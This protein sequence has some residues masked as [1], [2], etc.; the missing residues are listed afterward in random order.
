M[1][2]RYNV[3]QDLQFTS[4]AMVKAVNKVYQNK[5]DK[6]HTRWGVTVGGKWYWWVPVSQVVGDNGGGTVQWLGKMIR[7]VCLGLWSSKV[8]KIGVHEAVQRK[9]WARQED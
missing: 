8:K 4:Q 7:L 5:S 3:E 6:N 1:I 9:I 2:T